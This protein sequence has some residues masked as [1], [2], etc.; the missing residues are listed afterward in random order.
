ME[1]EGS[2]YGYYDVLTKKSE[3]THITAR[4]VG[5]SPARCSTSDT[6]LFY[7]RCQLGILLPESSR[8]SKK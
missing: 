5:C 3:I 8:A 7:L 2:S 4:E 6:R 1:V